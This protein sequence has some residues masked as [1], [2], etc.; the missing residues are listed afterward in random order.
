[1]SDKIST[2]DTSVETFAGVQAG[3]FKRVFEAQQKAELP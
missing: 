1:M 2:R 3:Y